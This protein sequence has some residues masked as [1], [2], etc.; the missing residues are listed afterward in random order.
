MLTFEIHTIN[1]DEHDVTVITGETIDDI[2]V[3]AS[4]IVEERHPQDCWSR[5][6]K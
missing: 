5:E 2:H 3:Q 6:V 4:K 1:N